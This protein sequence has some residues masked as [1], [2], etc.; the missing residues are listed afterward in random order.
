MFV[1]KAG[2]SA[3]KLAFA[4]S[5]VGDSAIKRKGCEYCVRDLV[6]AGASLQDFSEVGWASV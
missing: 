4:A 3:I 5:T 2:H 6:I 1:A